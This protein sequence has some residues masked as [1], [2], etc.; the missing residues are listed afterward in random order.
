L[1]HVC[2]R[3]GLDMVGGSNVCAATEALESIVEP[4]KGGAERTGRIQGAKL[5]SPNSM[6]PVDLF[7]S[8]WSSSDDV[9]VLMKV[10]DLR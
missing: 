8:D 6:S 1:R 3:Y 2:S 5:T 10:M 7:R 4:I 9:S